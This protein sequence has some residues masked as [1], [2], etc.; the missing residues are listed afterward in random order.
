MYPV[1][2][3]RSQRSTKKGD[4]VIFKRYIAVIPGHIF[5]GRYCVLT[6]LVRLRKG[7]DDNV[8]AMQKRGIARF[9]SMTVTKYA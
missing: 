8:V 9:L 1:Y 7:I 5:H 3:K 2:P 4:N 6:R